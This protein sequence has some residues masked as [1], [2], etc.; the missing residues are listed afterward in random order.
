ML[1]I[2]Y[3]SESQKNDFINLREGETKIGEKLT[4]AFNEDSFYHALKNTQIKYVILGIPEDIGP[5]ANLGKGGSQETFSLFCKA[6]CNI[7]SNRFLIGNEILFL[8]EVICSDLMLTAERLDNNNKKDL[9]TLRTLVSEID[10]RVAPII[11][12]IVKSGKTPIIIGG[13]HNNSYPCIKGAA[14]GLFENN[15]IEK[16]FIDCLNFDA[17]AD[18]RPLEGRHSGNGFRQAFKEK[19]LWKYAVIGLHQNYNSETMLQKMDEYPHRIQYSFFDEIISGLLG[20]ERSINDALIFLSAEPIGLELDLDAII[21]IASSA[22]SPSGYEVQHAR[23]FV[24]HVAYNHKVAYLHICEAAPSLN[25]MGNM[26]IGKLIAYLVSDFI[27]SL[28]LK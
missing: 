24:R 22:Q 3:I 15:S 4:F 8:G 1:A 23:K 16:P 14:E 13:G 21:N 27:K 19:F 7:Q 5:R 9:E 12:E 28:N 17:H 26:G 10:K 20:F 6:F 11:K 18:F 2:N 25:A